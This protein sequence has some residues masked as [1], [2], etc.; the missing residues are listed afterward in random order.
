MNAAIKKIFAY[1]PRTELF[2][3]KIYFGSNK[4]IKKFKKKNNFQAK[5]SYKKK[6]ISF[7]EHS[8]EDGDVIIVHSRMSALKSLGFSLDE[9]VSLLIRIV[10]PNGSIFIPNMPYYEDFAELK[11]IDDIC[12]KTLIYSQNQT[13][14]WTGVLGDT[15]V[16]KNHAFRSRSPLCSLAGLGPC[17]REVFSEELDDDFVFGIKSPW[18]KLMQI[19]AKILFLGAEAYDSIT[20]AHLVEDSFSKFPYNKWHTKV[21]FKINDSLDKYLFV[22]KPFWN[23]YLTEFYNIRMLKKNGIIHCNSIQGFEFS[24]IPSYK[25]LYDY[26]CKCSLNNRNTLFRVPKKYLKG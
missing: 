17:V 19:D 14:S 13:P 21:H 22:R 11:G 10:G 18:F 26:Y 6:V 24:C 15:F 4:R 5:S 2:A 12:D 16:K 20:E 8:I 9:L 25:R 3:R 1:F 7:L 23:K